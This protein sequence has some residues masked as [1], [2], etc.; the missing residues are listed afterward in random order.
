MGYLLMAKANFRIVLRSKQPKKMHTQEELK[1]SGMIFQTTNIL[2]NLIFV[3]KG[4]LVS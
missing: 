1:T 3:V 4:L 2:L